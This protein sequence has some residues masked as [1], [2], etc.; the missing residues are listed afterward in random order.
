MMVG[1]CAKKD[2]GGEAPLDPGAFDLGESPEPMILDPRLPS[3]GFS[4]IHEADDLRRQGIK[5][6]E[7]AT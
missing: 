5:V 7:D 1:A 3:R 6:A 4:D 2:S